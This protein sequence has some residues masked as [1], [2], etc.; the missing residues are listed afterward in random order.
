MSIETKSLGTNQ[1]L[2]REM[3]TSLSGFLERVEV[4][5]KVASL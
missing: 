4:I 1:L 5:L 3:G 2:K